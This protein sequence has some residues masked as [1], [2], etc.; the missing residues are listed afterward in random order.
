[1]VA[2]V[3]PP[4]ADDGGPMKSSNTAEPC[5]VLVINCGSTTMKFQLIETQ[6]GASLAKGSV[7]RIG[8]PDCLGRMRAGAEGSPGREER[9]PD[10]GHGQAM[11]WVF[12][13]LP[14]G[15]A[16]DAVGHRVVHGGVHFSQAAFVTDECLLKIEDCVPLAPLHN[17]VQLMG[18]R[19]CM[20]L[21]PELPQVAT[22]DTAFHQAKPRLNAMFGLP[23]AWAEGLGYRKFGFHG[24]SH[25]YVSRRAAALLGKDPGSLRLVTCHLGGGC[26]VTAVE[27]GVA[28]ESSANFGTCTGMPM[29]TR[30]GDL[31]AGVILDLLTRQKMSPEAIHELLYKKSGLLGIS[32]VSDD[33]A[34]L[35]RLESQGHEGARLARDYFVLALKRFIGSYAAVMDG[36][37]GIVFTAG[38][39]EHDSELRS[40]VC[41]G[42]GWLGATLDPERNRAGA[43]E[44]LISTPGSRVALMVIP[45][46]E[47][48]EIA[49]EVAELVGRAAP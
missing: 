38:I 31:D 30:S 36:V 24:A 48:L 18:I 20:R 10:R 13:S 25:K 49:T 37:D 16:P 23:L 26:S 6:T 39:G 34:E 35:G 19:E 12:D 28:V 17:P 3:S 4:R 47:E 14:P 43:G 32:G 33:M 15:M 45:T 5:S 7:D 1:M 27:R 29:G 9:L 44:A 46:N 40:R 21:H 42:L 2:G 41:E 22:F 8:R 11:K